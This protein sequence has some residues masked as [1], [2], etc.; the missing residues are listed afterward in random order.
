[1][2]WAKYS[3]ASAACPVFTRPMALPSSARARSRGLESCCDVLLDR[4]LVVAG[5]LGG[6]PEDVVCLGDGLKVLLGL[7]TRG[8]LEA[9]RVPFPREPAKG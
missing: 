2:A 7:G 4:R 1:M 3:L 9:V 5:A 8:T 6:I